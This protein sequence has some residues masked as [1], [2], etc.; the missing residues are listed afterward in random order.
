MGSTYN[1]YNQSVQFPSMQSYST[2]SFYNVNQSTRS[3]Q[4]IGINSGTIEG[5]GDDLIFDTHYQLDD[6]IVKGQKQYKRSIGYPIFGELLSGNLDDRGYGPLNEADIRLP[7]Y[8]TLNVSANLSNGITGEWL[9]WNGTATI[10]RHLQIYL[11]P[12]GGNLG[13]SISSPSFSLTANWMLQSTTPTA[14]QTYNFLSGHGASFTGG[15]WL[16]LNFGI[17]PA[18]NVTKTSFGFGLV[19]PQFGGSYNYTPEWLIFN[20]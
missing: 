3:F 16:G 2:T 19:S 7:D 8:Y 10:D 15:Y 6:V 12:F 5:E 13:K 17:S 20:K 14:S 1:G 4:Q 18:N 9:G 11:S